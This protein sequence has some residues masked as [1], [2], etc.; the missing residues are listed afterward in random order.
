M[1]KSPGFWPNTHAETGITKASLAPYGMPLSNRNA[2]GS[3]APSHVGD[4]RWT[5]CHNTAFITAAPPAGFE[6]VAKHPMPDPTSPKAAVSG[7]NGFIGEHLSRALSSR[8]LRVMAIPQD[9]LYHSEALKELF[10]REK[11]EYIFHL[12][13]YGNMASQKDISE[14]FAA[15]LVS[16]FNMLKESLA[17]PYRCFINFGTSS[18][19][20]RKTVAMS[21]QDSLGPETLYAATKAGGSHMASAFAIQYSKPIF[22]VRPFSVYGPAEADFRFIPTVIRSMLT[23]KSFPL[24]AQANHDWIYVE[25]LVEGV[26]RV[27]ENAS[28]ANGDRVFNIGSGRMYSN[29]QV[30]DTLKEVTGLTY[31]ATP[32]PGLRRNDSQVWRSDN[33]RISKLGFTPRYTLTE[34]L[35]LTFQYYKDKYESHT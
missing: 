33:D 8:G 26:L 30:C 10:E 24:D 28:H 1:L 25:D 23:G 18:E 17:C 5:A 31:L 15:N 21:E 14:I 4:K 35:R 22:T 6:N 7:H 11:P 16:T 29:Q 32:L 27:M 34:G 3:P 20:G 2:A 12:A 19:Y 13:A 9:T